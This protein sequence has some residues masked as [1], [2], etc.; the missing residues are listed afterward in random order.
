[1]GGLIG[2]N[3]GTVSQSYSIGNVKADSNSNIG[4]SAC[5]STVQVSGASG[6]VSG[7]FDSKIGDLIGFNYDS[8]VL[9][10]FATGSVT[11]GANS[12]VGGL[13]GQDGWISEGFGCGYDA[14]VTQSYSTGHVIGGR[15][16]MRCMKMPSA[17]CLLGHL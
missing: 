1:V 16:A 14:Y 11:G 15:P 4:F 10:A 3:C 9:Q 17:W 7:K 2:Y 12:A 13:V 6:Q 8:Y 5:Y